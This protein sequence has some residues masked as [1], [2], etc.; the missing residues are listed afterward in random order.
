MTDTIAQLLADDVALGRRAA[1]LILASDG[2]VNACLAA[3]R[4]Q[5][6]GAD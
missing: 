6:P 5:A 1:E 3:V 4:V 2:A